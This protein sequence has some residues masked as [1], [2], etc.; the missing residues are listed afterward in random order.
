MMR[1]Q[2]VLVIVVAP[3]LPSRAVF[4]DPQAELLGSYQSPIFSETPQ[5][6]II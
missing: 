4:P 3:S 6:T 2:E 1:M 5:N